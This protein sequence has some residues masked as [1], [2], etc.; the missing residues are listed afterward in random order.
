MELSLHQLRVFVTV[1]QRQSFTRAAEELLLSQPAVSMQIKA[2]ERTVGVSLFDHVGKRTQLTEAGHELYAR[3]SRILALTAETAE[4]MRALRGDWRRRLRVIATTTVGI[5]VVPTLLGQFHKRHPEVEIQLEVANWE[6]TCERLL[7]R[8]ADVGIAGPHPQPFLKMEPFMEDELVVI[9]APGHPLA[10]RRQ[11]PLERLAREPMLLRE[12]GSGTRAAVEGLFAEQNL[13]FRRAMELSRNGA[14]KQV[15][16][17]GLGIGVVSRAAITLEMALNILCV[18]D[19][20]GFPLVRAWHIITQSGLALP[21]AA[22]AFCAE[23]ASS[24][25]PQDHGADTCTMQIDGD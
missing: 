8:E 21:P 22:V 24:V 12:L 9:A 23:V 13:P 19:V 20:E 2:L 4:T 6:L 14:I 17:A 1:A 25:S 18:L 11:I 15:V 16:A 10:S 3:A 7:D 5:Y